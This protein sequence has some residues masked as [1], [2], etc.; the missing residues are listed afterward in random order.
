M[1]QSKDKTFTNYAS[2]IFFQKKKKKL[3][4]FLVDWLLVFNS[5]KESWRGIRFF[6]KQKYVK[7]N[8]SRA[9]I[10]MRL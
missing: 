5:G 10:Y 4:N 8:I 3:G 6:N 1:V 9:K 7:R 2:C